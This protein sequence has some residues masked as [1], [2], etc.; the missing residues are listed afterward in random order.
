MTKEQIKAILLKYGSGTCTQDER[1]LLETWFLKQHVENIPT[2]AEIED[3]LDQ[4]WKSIKNNQ[5]RRSI[6]SLPR[7]AAAASIILGLSVCGYFWVKR[8]KSELQVAQNHIYDIAPG[9][10]EAVLTL[11]NGQKIRLTDKQNGLIAQQAGKAVMVNSRGRLNY[12]DNA[13]AGNNTAESVYNTL[14]TP[15]GN[16]RDM[17]LSDGTEVSLDAGSSITFPV[18]FDQKERSVSI[19]GQ[20]YF[21]VKHNAVWPF[22]V[23]VKGVTVRDIGTE[24]NINSYDD[25]P[26]VKTTLVAGSIKL[27][28]DNQEALLKPGDQAI[29]AVSTRGIK[30][31]KVDVEPVVAWK[32]GDFIFKDEDFKTAMRQIARW[33]NVEIS[34]D[35]SASVDIVPGGWISRSKNISVVLRTMELTG[36]IHFKIEGRRIIVTK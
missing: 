8:D 19:T 3:D 26:E 22:A 17:T 2:S 15:L 16:H 21:K 7:I 35:P 11:S 36:D 31:A 9:G 28:K 34:Y 33:Y 30:V 1:A 25:E 5:H 14:T 6:I 18:V 24:F 10:N 12:A 13:E 29:T 20:V 4:I 32:N 23:K 27:N